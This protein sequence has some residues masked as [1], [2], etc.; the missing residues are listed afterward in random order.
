MDIEV[1]AAVFG[2][3]DQRLSPM[4]LESGEQVVGEIGV[5]QVS[6]S[7]QGVEQTTCEHGESEVW[8]LPA[9]CDGGKAVM[10]SR[11]SG[12]A[13]PARERPSISVQR[14]LGIDDGTG[15]VWLPNL[16]EGVR[17]RVSGTVKDSAVQSD[18]AGMSRRHKFIVTTIRKSVVKERADGLAGAMIRTCG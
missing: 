1:I 7:E 10:T 12:C 15:A 17:N 9:G 14:A 5:R 8:D 13:A 16:H 11:V 4:W 2:L 18:R 6:P 3:A